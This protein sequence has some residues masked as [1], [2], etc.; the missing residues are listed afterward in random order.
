MHIYKSISFMSILFQIVKT[1]HYSEIGEY[2]NELW[3][4]FFLLATKIKRNELCI[5]W[6][7]IPKIIML[8][9][10][11]QTK[12]YYEQYHCICIRF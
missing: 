7:C 8:H 4:I 2:I 9:E 6:G 10:R 12:I 11:S 5:L 1:S 3:C